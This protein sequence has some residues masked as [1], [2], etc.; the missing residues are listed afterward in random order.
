MRTV[1]EVEP[2][3]RRPSA[4][5]LLSAVEPILSEALVS[6]VGAS[7]QVDIILPGGARSTFFIDLSSGG[8]LTVGWAPYGISS[9]SVTQ[10]MAAPSR[11][12]RVPQAAGGLAAVCPRAA[13]MWCWRWRRRTCRS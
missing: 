1:S 8:G 11:P 13:L 10:L 12:I 3:R 7:Y 6:Q 9:W 4:V 2:P 5:E